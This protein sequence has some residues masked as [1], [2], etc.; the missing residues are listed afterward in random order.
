MRDAIGATGLDLSSMIV[1]TEAAS[2]AYGVTPV[3]AALANARYV[4]GFV[5]STP[6]GTVAEVTAWTI[7]LASAAGVGGRISRDRDHL[8]DA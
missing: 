2:G 7:A 5:R 8:P 4:Y 6:H 3:I 1:L